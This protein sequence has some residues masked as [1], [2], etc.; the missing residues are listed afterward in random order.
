MRVKSTMLPLVGDKNGIKGKEAASNRQ[1]LAAL[2]KALQYKGSIHSVKILVNAFLDSL[3][4]FDYAA[5]FHCKDEDSA[6]E[7]SEML[8]RPVQPYSL[9]IIYQRF[10]R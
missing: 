9:V 3:Q 10:H 8:N 6:N 7:L 4:Q 2:P 5:A 1:L